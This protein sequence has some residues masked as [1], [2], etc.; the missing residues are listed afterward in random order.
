MDTLLLDSNWDL[1][2]DE[3]GNIAVAMGG[4]AIEQDVASAVRLFAGEL[5]YDTSKGL[6]YWTDTLGHQPPLALLKAQIE[7][8]ALT[9]PEVAEAQCTVIAVEKRGITGQIRVI[10]NNGVLR[11]VAF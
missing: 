8:S 7:A 1:T 10:D 2:L 6:P 4:Y 9:V 3:K 11:N 5:Y